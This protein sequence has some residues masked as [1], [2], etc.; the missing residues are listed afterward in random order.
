[1][2]RLL[3]LYAERVVVKLYEHALGVLMLIAVVFGTIG[4]VIAYACCVVSGECSRAEEK[5]ERQSKKLLDFRH[6]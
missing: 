5:R 3:V 6:Q 2:Y 1:M 4:G